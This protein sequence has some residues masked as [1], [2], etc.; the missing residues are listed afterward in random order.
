MPIVN[1][2]YKNGFVVAVSHPVDEALGAGAEAGKTS[3]CQVVAELL[4]VHEIEAVV[5]VIV[6]RVTALG[7]GQ[8]GAGAQVTFEVQPEAVTNPSLLKLKVKH[9]SGLEEVNGPGIVVPQ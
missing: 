8:V 7:F 9:P 5:C 1:P 3:T 4:F 2:G 6:P